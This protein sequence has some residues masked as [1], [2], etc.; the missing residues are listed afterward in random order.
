MFNDIAG[1]EYIGLD[2]KLTQSGV[3]VYQTFLATQHDGKFISFVI[4]SLVGADEINPLLD[5]ITT[6][7]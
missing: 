2:A 3:T 5:K 4:T 7:K 6:V 1:K